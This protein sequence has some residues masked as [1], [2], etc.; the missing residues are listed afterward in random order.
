MKKAALTVLRAALVDAAIE[1]MHDMDAEAKHLE[2][3][4]ALEAIAELIRTAKATRVSLQHM[5][6]PESV[7]QARSVELDS[8]LR[9]IE[10]G[11]A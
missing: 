1:R 7:I 5:R 9:V 3:E 6:G 8:A 10:G 2:A 4:A 11:A